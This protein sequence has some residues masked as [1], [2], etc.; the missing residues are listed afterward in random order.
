M[1]LRSLQDEK[2]FLANHGRQISNDFVGD[3]KTGD[4]MRR[5]S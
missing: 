5:I 2:I 4:G 1:H 3:R